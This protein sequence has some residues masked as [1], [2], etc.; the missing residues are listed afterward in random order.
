MY[1][2]I[3]DNR[4]FLWLYVHPEGLIYDTTS[5]VSSSASSCCNAWE[6]SKVFGLKS[7]FHLVSVQS[8]SANPLR[9]HFFAIML[10]MPP[11]KVQGMGV[12][13]S[14]NS[15]IYNWTFVEEKKVVPRQ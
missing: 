12:K 13:Q 2:E 10:Q 11:V 7:A 6:S 15:R 9:S 4:I 5:G 1:F 14:V 8:D 3:K